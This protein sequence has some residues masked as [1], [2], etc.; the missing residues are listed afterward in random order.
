M[1]SHLVL[2]WFKGD[3]KVDEDCNQGEGDKESKTEL[4]VDTKRNIHHVLDILQQSS[5]SINPTE[6]L[7]IG[8]YHKFQIII[9]DS[10]N[11]NDSNH[12]DDEATSKV[13]HQRQ[14][15]LSSRCNIHNPNTESN[16]TDYASDHGLKKMLKYRV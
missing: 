12:K 6:I 10:N 7:G 3:N 1:L 14:D 16:D 8:F 15:C 4:P 9:P 2:Q 11:L 5:Q 13:V